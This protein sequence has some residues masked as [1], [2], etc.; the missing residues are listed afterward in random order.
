MDNKQTKKNVH[1]GH[2]QR[3]RDRV[4]EYGLSQLKDHEVLELLLFYIIPRGNTN[5]IAHR[6]IDSFGSLKGVLDAD[7]PELC[8]IAGVGEQSA[9]FLKT[10][11]EVHRR[12]C[13]TRVDKRILYKSHDDYCAL[14]VSRLYG[15]SKEKVLAFC[16]DASGRVKAEIV[17]SEGTENTSFIDVRKIVQGA[18]GCDATIVV[19]AHNHPTG[20]GEPSASD[21]DATR[22]LSVTLRKLQ[23]MLADH[24]IVDENN[25][26]HSMYMMPEARCVFY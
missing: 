21:M 7:V 16:L 2:R 14:A 24:V 18:M 17:V 3:V 4:S 11:G 9:L 26:A 6:L 23:V 8:C 20:S 15:E 12:S 13:Q 5:D 10:I 25:Q 1:D 22:S 19:L